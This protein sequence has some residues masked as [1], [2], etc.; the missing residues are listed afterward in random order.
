MTTEKPTGIEKRIQKALDLDIKNIYFNGFVNAVGHGDILIILERNTKPVAI[1]NASYSVAKTLA[2]K[3]NE[4]V[5]KFEAD[6]DHEIMT[7]DDVQSKALKIAK[8]KAN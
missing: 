5:Q 2:I 7:T 8:R 4:I 3:L 6:M 1:L